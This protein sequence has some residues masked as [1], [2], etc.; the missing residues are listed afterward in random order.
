[1]DSSTN[2]CISILNDLVKLAAKYQL[3]ISGEFNLS[4]HQSKNEIDNELF[5]NIGLQ[6]DDSGRLDFDGGI[7]LKLSATGE[8]ASIFTLCGYSCQLLVS[9]YNLNNE[10]D[11]LENYL[12][13]DSEDCDFLIT[14]KDIAGDNTEALAEKLFTYWNGEKIGPI[15]SYCA[16]KL[17]GSS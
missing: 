10:D 13:T 15:R 8:L 2:K 7:E 5:G 4:R 17:G 6:Y 3:S 12:I 11:E 1:M 9:I 14:S 16:M